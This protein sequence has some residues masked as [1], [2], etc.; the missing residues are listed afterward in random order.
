MNESYDAAPRP[1]RRDYVS[2]KA[3]SVFSGPHP[4]FLSSC[5]GD[6][7]NLIDRHVALNTIRHWTRHSLGVVN[8]A[9]P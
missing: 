9:T 7:G 2:S 4:C 6:A 5:C 8:S 3:A 1:E